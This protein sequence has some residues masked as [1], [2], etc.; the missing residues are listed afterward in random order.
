MGHTFRTKVVSGVYLMEILVCITGASGVIYGIRLLEALREISEVKTHLILSPIAERII[1]YET[2]YS[3]EYVWKLADQVYGYDDLFAL[4]ASG[5]SPLDSMVI[6]PCSM[7]TLASIANGI[8]DNLITRAADCMLKERRKLVLVVRETPLNIIQIRNMLKVS[9]AGAIVLPA[10]PAFYNKPKTI[11]DLVNY[12]V[13]KVLDIIGIRHN[14]YK[15][16]QGLK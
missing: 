1:E 12:I 8:S 10:A 9:V 4:P 6:I 15:R 11:D 16:W 13:G 14:L 5:S 2:T 3:V 7:K